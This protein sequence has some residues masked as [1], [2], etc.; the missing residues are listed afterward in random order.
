M[1]RA[2]WEAV[3]PKPQT[4]FWLLC[5]YECIGTL[6]Q[7]SIHGMESSKPGISRQP[8]ICHN[9]EAMMEM[10]LRKS[11]LGDGFSKNLTPPP[12]R[13]ACVMGISAFWDACEDG[14]IQGLAST[15]QLSDVVVFLS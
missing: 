11:P 15:Y 6:L 3:Q 10:M 5:T 9:D 1:F 12:R 7:E 8:T 14:W 13:Q 2:G 4:L